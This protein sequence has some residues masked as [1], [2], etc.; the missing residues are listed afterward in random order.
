MSLLLAVRSSLPESG[1]RS[2]LQLDQQGTTSTPDAWL[3]ALRELL[4]RDVGLGV[5]VEGSSPLT[6]SCQSHLRDLCGRLGQGGWGL[7][8]AL[9]SDPEP[10]GRLSQLSG[11]R[12]KRTEGE[13]A[14][15]E[16]ERSP[17]R[18]RGCEEEQEEVVERKEQEERPKPET[19]ESESDAGG[20]LPDTEVEA[21]EA[22]PG[23]AEAEGPA[24]S[25]ELPKVVQV[26]VGKLTETRFSSGSSL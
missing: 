19:S 1:L 13:T 3:H 12:R 7:K 25:V 16:L 21:P 17:K 11:K 18:F 24:E 5:S 4:Q 22:R 8:P 2:V 15:P 14:G 9:G 20:V 10:E 23:V 26:L 6:G